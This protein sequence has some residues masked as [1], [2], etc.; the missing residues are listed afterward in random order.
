MNLLI[1][2]I[3]H[4]GVIVAFAAALVAAYGYFQASRGRALDDPDMQKRLLVDSLK[5]IVAG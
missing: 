3:G 2:N 5:P 1:G 4:L